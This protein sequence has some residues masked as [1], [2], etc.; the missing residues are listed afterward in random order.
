MSNLRQCGYCEHS[1]APNAKTCPA[2]GG[3]WP[4][5]GR[6]NFRLSVERLH[7][8]IT[9]IGWVEPKFKAT[10]QTYLSMIMEMI[11]AIIGFAGF[12]V[13]NLA[14]VS[15]LTILFT[16]GKSGFASIQSASDFF[17]YGLD[18]IL[19]IIVAYLV[20]AAGIIVFAHAK[21]LLKKYRS[22]G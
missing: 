3:Q 10:P 6:S 15:F 22:G 8:F 9:V 4:I 20:F 2:C 19:W 12:I 1:V 13:F 7:A 11:A 21:S 17:S 16:E 5:T 18:V 14:L